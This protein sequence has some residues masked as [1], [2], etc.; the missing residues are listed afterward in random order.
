MS[1]ERAMQ[2]YE[3]L[4]ALYRDRDAKQGMLLKAFLSVI[5]E[6][7]DTVSR[8]TA[9][10][11][12]SWFI[13]TCPDWV[14]PYL[15]E[16]LG[17]QPLPY[18]SL[19]YNLRR[20]V[21]STLTQRRRKGTPAGLQ[22]ISQT[23]TAWPT[24]LVE[25]RRYVVAAQ[26]L[27]ALRP[28]LVSLV[29]VRD[30]ATLARR[31][32]PFDRIPRAVDLRRPRGHTGR[33]HPGNLGLFVWRQKV[34]RC[35][36]M[37]A[38][39]GPAAG[40]VR[41][42]PYGAG[43]P[44]CNPRPAPAVVTRESEAPGP[45]LPAAL[46]AEIQ[47]LV[48]NS[49]APQVYFGND[50]VLSIQLV[51][52]ST[53][54]S[55][56]PQEIL[57]ADLSDFASGWAVPTAAGWA[58]NQ[59]KVALDPSRGRL[60]L[61][62][63]LATMAVR[64]SYGYIS[65]DEIGAGPFDRAPLAADEQLITVGTRVAANF[66]TLAQ[67]LAAVNKPQATIE[68][69]DNESYDLPS[70]V[71]TTT[72]Q[73]ITIR[74]QSGKMPRIIDGSTTTTTTTSTGMSLMVKVMQT[75]TLRGAGFLRLCGLVLPG[76]Q[77]AADSSASDITLEQCSLLDL[78]QQ[79]QGD[80]PLHLIKCLASNG[81]AWNGAVSVQDSGL[82]NRSMATIVSSTGT[83]EDFGTVLVS[84]ARCDIARSTF[85]GGVT[86]A[87]V[88][89]V[90]DSLIFGPLQVTRTAVGSVKNS[91]F[92]GGATAPQRCTDT[93]EVP[94]VTKPMFVSVVPGELGY[95]Q[96][97]TAAP[98]QILTGAS[99]GG[100]MGIWNRLAMVQREGNLRAGIEEYVPVGFRTNIYYAT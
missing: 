100:Q 86:A 99:D 95:L 72:G 28:D 59:Y 19:G 54:Q 41:F 42:H 50:P 81:V 2:L 17:I 85:L 49:A 40:L 51:S 46:A 25:Y 52:G 22:Q 57:I 11:Y 74:A 23:F 24:L 79:S 21:A 98:L 75:L 38:S 30:R 5:Q 92:V 65:G 36:D 37:P 43:T 1:Q 3:L 15:A 76:F 93:F 96:L 70:T 48:A 80:C 55:V 33:F 64:V 68:I 44:L 12:D 73:R 20:L 29:S 9:E 60:R 77:I 14:V 32:T 31:D 47:S 62:A 58:A 8:D 34:Y 89:S 91:T 4:P 67:A 97:G 26:H 6:S 84:K 78:L 61:R 18:P 94:A 45:L 56:L 39:A 7:L 27:Q 83:R 16:R 35:L 10:L 82:Q 71:T 13:E 66:P 87:E 88:G 53:V 69:R 90:T 63:N